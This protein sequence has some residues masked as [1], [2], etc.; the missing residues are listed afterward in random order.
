MN[1]RALQSVGNLG[2][3]ME[4]AS[5]LLDES[6]ELQSRFARLGGHGALVVSIQHWLSFFQNRS[7]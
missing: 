5:A 2:R 4:H 7:G 6:G 3:R 1:T